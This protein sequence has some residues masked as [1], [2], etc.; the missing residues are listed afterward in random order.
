M[1][2]MVIITVSAGDIDGE[3]WGRRC[4]GEKIRGVVD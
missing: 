4:G 3:F 2:Q 1:A